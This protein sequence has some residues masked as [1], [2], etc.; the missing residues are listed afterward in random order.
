MPILTFNQFHAVRMPEFIAVG[1]LGGPRFRTSV[2]EAGSGHEFRNAELSNMRH[3]WNVAQSIKTQAEFDVIKAFFINRYGRTF[4][5]LFKDWSD[6]IATA[7]NIGTGDSLTRIFQL[8]K[9]YTDGTFSV[10]RNIA[11]PRNDTDAEGDHTAKMFF[12]A[13]EQSTGTWS[14]NVDTGLVTFGGPPPIDVAVTW[15]GEFDVPSR[16]QTDLMDSRFE[17]FNILSWEGVIIR[18]LVP[19]VV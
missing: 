12:D 15:T 9:T 17:D 16:F 2:V 14:L 5:F 8:T 11:K 3:Q 4:G 13:V 6:F 7:E 10:V 19:N 1:A 18:E